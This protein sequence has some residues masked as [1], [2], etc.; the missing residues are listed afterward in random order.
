MTT[1]L[2]VSSSAFP[3]GPAF[4]LSAVRSVRSV[5]SARAIAIPASLRSLAGFEVGVALIVFL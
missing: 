5:R 2:L 3:G 1:A 4:G